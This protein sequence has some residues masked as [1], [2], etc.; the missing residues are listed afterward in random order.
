MVGTEAL[1]GRDLEQ[2][3]HERLAAGELADAGN[4][5]AIALRIVVVV[6]ELG[7]EDIGSLHHDDLRSFTM[8]WSWR[9][10]DHKQL[11]L[12]LAQRCASACC[13]SSVRTRAGRI[14]ET[15][16]AVM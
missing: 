11:V 14:G 16:P 5:R 6:L 12:A 7:A 3:D 8:R 10:E 15:A 4:A 2:L 13:P 1:S 9:L